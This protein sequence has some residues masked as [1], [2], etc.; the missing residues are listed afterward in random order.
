ML[1]S[2]NVAKQ[3]TL[4]E[5][6]NRKAKTQPLKKPRTHIPAN[7]AYR[8]GRDYDD[9][10]DD[11]DESESSSSDSSQFQDEED[12]DEEEEVFIASGCV[13]PA[14]APVLS[15]PVVDQQG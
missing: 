2:F 12:D 10:Y 9:D 14:A 1:K 5:T 8:K 7:A 15:V 13:V 3:R 6:S 4:S 11:D